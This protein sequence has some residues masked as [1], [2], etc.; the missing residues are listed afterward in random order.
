MFEP[1]QESELAQLG[2]LDKARA[3]VASGS[4]AEDAAKAT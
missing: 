4:A 3:M 2:C 1:Y